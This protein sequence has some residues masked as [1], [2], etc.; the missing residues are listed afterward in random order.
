MPARHFSRVLL[1]EPLRPTMPKN[2]PSGMSKLTSSSA[3]RTSEPVRRNGCRARSFRVCTRSCGRTNCLVTSSTWITGEVS[4]TWAVRLPA[5]SA[6]GTGPPPGA[7]VRLLETSLLSL[8]RVAWH[9]D[10][11]P[12]LG[13]LRDLHTYRRARR[14]H[15]ELFE[16]GWTML[17]PRRGR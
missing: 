4:D 13:E 2:S 16:G 11:L 14:L 7:R 10:R 3:R 1:P 9:L 6:A 17:G 5:A 15:Q 8:S 12:R